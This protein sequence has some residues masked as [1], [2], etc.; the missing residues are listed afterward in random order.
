[1]SG[2]RMGARSTAVGRRPVA[3]RRSPHGRVVAVTLVTAGARQS[4]PLGHY[5]PR[6]PRRAHVRA[7]VDNKEVEPLTELEVSEDF[8]PGEVRLQDVVSLWATNIMQTY[9]DAESADGAP[10]AEGVLDD[11]VGGPLFL[12]LEKYAQ[13]YGSIYKLAF[14]PKTFMIVS[15]PVMA[16]H[17]LFTEAFSF[18]KGVLAEILE[19]IMGKGLIPADYETWKVRRRAVRPGFHDAWLQRMTTLFADCTDNLVGKLERAAAAGSVLDMEVE[20]CSLSLDIIG[21]AVFNYDFGSVTK[22]SPVIKA[23]YNTL[24]EAEH[25]STFYFPY[26]NIPGASL[27]VPRQR[28]FQADLRTIN[29]TLNM[30]IRKAQASRS[31]SDLEE[32]EAR[33]YDNVQDPS[34]LRFLVDLRGE[35]TTNVQLRDD[36]MTML[37]AGH[38]TT[39][40]VLT[41]AAFCLSQNPEQLR[42]VQQEVDEV[43]ANKSRPDYA[44]LERLQNVRFTVAEAL[45]LYPEPPLLIRRALEEVTLPKGASGVNV[46]LLKGMDIFVAVWNIHRSPDLWDEPEKFDITRWLRPKSNPG[47]EGW[48]GYRPELLKGFYPNEIAS[49]FA[50][51][52][53]G[54][55]SRKCVGDQFATMEATVALAM[56][57][58]R[59]E[60]D[61]DIKPEDVGMVTGATIHTENG[62]PMR[63]R[64]RASANTTEPAAV[65]S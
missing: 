6:Q 27:V 40:A 52:P 56:L 22:E 13:R 36:L 65:V 17:I 12:A 3:R 2:V 19:P 49:D 45:R 21:L 42:L 50:Y 38:E 29:D 5:R 28:Q 55:G 16:K 37:V 57:L 32:L 43:L 9:G 41:W 30:L 53:F 39:A 26:W 61:L 18:S 10:V 58:K 46:K 15:D 63:V 1:M 24:R 44:D 33:D 31:E 8:K 64:E 59:F 34:L 54:G 23:V 51:L 11:L 35:E 47:V 48:K 7:S 25:R 20:F 14:G 4:C 62:L 60:F